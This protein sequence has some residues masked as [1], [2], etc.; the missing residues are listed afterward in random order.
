MEGAVLPKDSPKMC[1]GTSSP[2]PYFAIEVS[3]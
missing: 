3:D 1:E 2:S